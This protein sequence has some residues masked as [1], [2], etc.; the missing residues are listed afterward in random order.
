MLILG[1]G[2]TAVAFQVL[3][4]LVDALVGG[5]TD[6]RLR[7]RVFAAYDVVYNLAFI[8]AGLALIPLWHLGREHS[9]LWGLAAAFVVAGAFVA[10]Q[11]RSWPFDLPWRTRQRPAHAWR[12]RLLAFAVGAL[13]VLAF[14]APA[15]W[16]LAWVCARSAAARRA[17]CSDDA[18]GW[19]SVPDGAEP[20]SC[21]RCSTGCSRT[22]ARSPSS[23]TRCSGC[24]GSRGAGSHGPCCS[25]RAIDGR[26]L[27]VSLVLVPSGW[28]VIEAIRS[29]Q[30]LGGPW[31]LLGA[32]Q[33]NV[34]P[35]LSLAALG[36]GLA[37]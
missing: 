19:A 27:A 13:P 25:R 32:S 7:G 26:R 5:A 22:S 17:W 8:I 6:D 35:T 14:P 9:L 24:C 37:A 11:M 31:G 28:I 30:S 10:R 15:L 20:A 1:V 33:W 21:W 34:R 12:V 23:S 4:V 29:W 16:W 36:R 3:K 18:G 2:A